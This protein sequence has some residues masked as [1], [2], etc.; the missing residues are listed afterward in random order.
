[1]IPFLID[2]GCD[3]II[4]RTLRKLGYDVTFVAEVSPGK[5]D[6]DILAW[7]N[8][9]RRVIMTEDRD[10]CE[11]VFRDEK[12]TFGIVL[13]RISDENRLMKAIQIT[14]LVN[15]HADELPS[16]MTTV[17]LNRIK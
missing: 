3:A 12:P 10:F 8:R 9:E 15:S 4:V 11:L 7:G 5:P 16:A 6:I 17:F 2:E 13:V 14:E 1:M